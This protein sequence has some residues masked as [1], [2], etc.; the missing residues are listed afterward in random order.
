MKYNIEIKVNYSDNHE[1]RDFLRNVF[2][3]NMENTPD[4]SYIEDLDNETK[5]EMSYDYDAMFEGMNYIFKETM[6]HPL[7]LELYEI[8]ASKMFSLDKN[9]GLAILF[10]YDYFALFHLCLVDFFTDPNTFTK[11]NIHFLT[12]K[13][14]IY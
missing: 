8:G 11:E 5:D 9:I 13:H 1:Y 4:L 14:K 7:F 12:L 2:Y 6:N 10:S 3:M